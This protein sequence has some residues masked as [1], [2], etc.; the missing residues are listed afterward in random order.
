MKRDARVGSKLFPAIFDARHQR[1]STTGISTSLLVRYISKRTGKVVNA[2]DWIAGRTNP[3][4]PIAQVRSQSL[5]VVPEWLLIRRPL[6]LQSPRSICPRHETFHGSLLLI[7][8][9]FRLALQQ[10]LNNG[11]SVITS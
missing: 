5:V 8:S 7:D 9:E 10:Y 6:S 4:V 11:E 2:R 3:K 1:A